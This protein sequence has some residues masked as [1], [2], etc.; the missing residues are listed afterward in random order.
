MGGC[1]RHLVQMV[2]LST[3]VFALL[4]ARAVW[5]NEDST[6]N[7][8]HIGSASVHR[9]RLR[10]SGVDGN[11][12]E[13]SGQT[14]GKEKANRHAVDEVIFVHDHMGLLK[15][16]E[17]VQPDSNQTAPSLRGQSPCG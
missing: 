10:R 1:C 3:I 14:P 12:D 8:Q 15:A 17:S 7:G 16:A 13:R 4:V 5:E 6:W 2:L 11:H 9:V